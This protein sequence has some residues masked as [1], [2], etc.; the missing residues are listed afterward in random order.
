MFVSRFIIA[1]YLLAFSAA[2]PAETQPA[3]S[4]P[5]CAVLPTPTPTSSEPASEVLPGSCYTTS[6]DFPHGTATV[7]THS[8]YTRTSIAPAPSCPTPSCSPPPTDQICPLFIKVSSVTVPCTTDC[9]PTTSTVYESKGPCPT[10]DPCRIPTEWVTYMTGCP[11]TPT[12][13]M[14]TIITPAF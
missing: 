4:G 12:I 5:E 10:C 7:I 14:S 3:G 13:T 9:C 1:G 6:D 11:G 8:C 2:F